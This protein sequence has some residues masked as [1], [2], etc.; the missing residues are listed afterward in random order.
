MASKQAGTGMAATP[1]AAG[2]LLVVL[3]LTPMSAR[4][5]DPS[6]KDLLG[7]AQTQSETKAVEDLIDKLKSRS[8]APAAKPAEPVKAAEPVK[9]EAAGASTG[10]AGGTEAKTPRPR[11]TSTGPEAAKA[12]DVSRN[13]TP[14][15]GA[16]TDAGAVA[17]DTAGKSAEAEQMSSVDLEVQFEYNSARIAREATGTLTTL[18]HAL[19]DTRLVGDS[20]LIA[21]HTDAKGAADYNLRLSQKRAESVRDFLIKNFGIE[22]RRLVAQG[23]GQKHLKNEADPLAAENRRVQIVNFTPPKRQ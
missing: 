4:A 22:P 3:A 20:F 5:D 7:K 12:P 21:G 15:S 17:P 16:G 13:D 8:K 18:G 23:F 19:T 6:V 11:E 1:L 10:Q 9:E 14:T 2:I